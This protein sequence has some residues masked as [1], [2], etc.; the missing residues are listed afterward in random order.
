MVTRDNAL[1]IYIPKTKTGK[2]PI[3]RLRV[4]AKEKERSLNYMIVEAILQY[5]DREGVEIDD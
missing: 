1:S 5:L 4:L 2:Q 3:A